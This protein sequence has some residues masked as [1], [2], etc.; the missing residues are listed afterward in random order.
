MATPRVHKRIKDQ[1]GKEIILTEGVLKHIQKTHPEVITWL[2]TALSAITNPDR[3]FD[4]GNEKVYVKELPEEVKSFVQNGVKYSLV[5]VTKRLEGY[6]AVKTCYFI[7][8]ETLMRR[9]W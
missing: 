3:V 6:L 8:E 5:P 2:D 7:T 4:Y 9:I 1:N